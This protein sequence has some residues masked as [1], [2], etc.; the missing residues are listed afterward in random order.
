[1]MQKY[2]TEVIAESDYQWSGIAVSKEKRFFVNFPTWDI[3][4]PFKVGE[5]VDGNI[6]AYPSE[7]DNELFVCVQSVVIDDLNRLW[8]LDPASPLFKGVVESGAKLFCVNI[9]TNKIDKTYV[10]PP[11][12]APKTSYLNDVRIDSK[13]GFAFMTDS[14][15]GGIIVLDL[16][17]G[18]SWRALDA[19]VGAVM[20][21]LDCIDFR[22]TG[23]W[24]KKINSDGIELSK[25]CE[26]LYFT[27]LT[28]NILYA[29]PTSVLRDHTM[30]V[31]EREKFIRIE[32]SNNVPS[33]G[34]LLLDDKLYMGNLPEEGIWQYDL[35]SRFGTSI[36]LGE[37]IRWA[38]SFACDRDGCIYFTTSQINYPRELQEKFKL[39]KM[40]KKELVYP[41]CFSH[42]GIT[43][44]DLKA[45]VKFYTEVMGWYV[46]MEPT[47]VKEESKTAIGEMCIDVFGKGW[48]SF[49]IAHLATGDKIG[50]EMFEF[51]LV[52]SVP[53]VC[54]GDR[55]GFEK[56]D[57]KKIK[58]ESP[59]FNPFRNGL[60]HFAVQDPDIEGLIEKI[61]AAG[62]RQRMPIREYYPGVKPY[63]MC[64]VED[65]FGIVFE[66][67]THSYE[68]TYSGGAY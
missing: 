26:T 21:N 24:N 10:F 19:S 28:G 1:M 56:V 5:I 52:D 39:R 49:L 27:A 2:S 9:E 34:M 38:D 23:K 12:V 64:Y 33:D 61:V 11:E 51:N 68:M 46:I 40:K 42:I 36:D 60:F 44:P 55:I 13:S 14:E 30:C 8:V 18:S 47:E 22:T 29:V 4:C 31:A 35:K 15:D 63:K 41:R 65:P 32:N 25:D 48:G 66:I 6:V 57:L 58:G 59:K 20:A 37:S 17:S 50:V 45:A 54:Q 16:Q 67:Y 53:P 43:V 3:P 62:G 7:K